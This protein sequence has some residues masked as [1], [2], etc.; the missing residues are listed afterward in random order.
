M[1]CLYYTYACICMYMWWYVHGEFSIVGARF[2]F[3]RKKLVADDRVRTDS[4]Q[5]TLSVS[6]VCHGTMCNVDWMYECMIV[7]MYISTVHVDMYISWHDIHTR[8]I[9]FCS[10]L[11]LHTVG[12]CGKRI[13]VKTAAFRVYTQIQQ[14]YQQQQQLQ[15][16]HDQA[17]IG[18]FGGAVRAKSPC[19][20]FSSVR[21]VCAVCCILFCI[22]SAAT[23]PWVQPSCTI[24]FHFSL[25]TVF[26]LTRSNLSAA[27][28]KN[29]YK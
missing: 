27:L 25:H 20:V 28:Q 29:L 23:L 17:H 4:T 3:N 5:Y 24:R 22:R 18:R 9:C 8:D 16:Q 21:V 10:F 11:S 26:A 13:E 2:N 15:Q 19:C 7:C 1:C 6:F 12:A 14:Q